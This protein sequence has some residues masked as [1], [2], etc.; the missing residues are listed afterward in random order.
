M[1]R[2]PKRAKR[3]KKLS[4]AER[5]AAS[6]ERKQMAE[7]L[8]YAERARDAAI[9]KLHELQERAAIQKVPFG[10]SES[11]ASRAQRI[12]LRN[13]EWIQKGG[14]LNEA[15]LFPLDTA[16]GPLELPLWQD[17]GISLSEKKAREL[18]DLFQMDRRDI[19]TIYFS[20]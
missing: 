4:I 2:K 1:S 17:A 6:A 8:A 5:F 12:S 20:P 11:L 15:Y 19:Y 9:A 7:R 10:T 18:A 14:K 16:F 3:A 13:N